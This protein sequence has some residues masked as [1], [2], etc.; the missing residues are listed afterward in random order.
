MYCGSVSKLLSIFKKIVESLFVVQ[1]DPW[2]REVSKKR[3]AI[4]IFFILLILI[5]AILAITVNPIEKIAQQKNDQQRIG[6]LEKLRQVLISYQ[7]ETGQLPKLP[8]D[9]RFSVG[10]KGSAAK[11]ENNWLGVDLSKYTGSVPVDPK[12]VVGSTAPYPY[13]YTT[14]G[15]TFKL[16]AY[17]ERNENNLMQKDS[18]ILN[19]FGNPVTN[20]TRYEVGTNLFLK[21]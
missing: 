8:A 14:D 3:V 7:A 2:T 10:G 19:E 6:D 21:F 4:F 17:L 11:S 16:D 9:T 18:G 1:V 12:F 15:S 13:R 20:K 5:G